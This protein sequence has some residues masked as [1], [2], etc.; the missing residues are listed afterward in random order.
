MTFQGFK[1]EQNLSL[2]TEIAEKT[3]VTEGFD[4]EKNGYQFQLFFAESEKVHPNGIAFSVQTESGE[5]LLLDLPTGE[6][7]IEFCRQAHESALQRDG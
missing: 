6:Q 7:L 4:P 1:E 3:I 5:K 2:I